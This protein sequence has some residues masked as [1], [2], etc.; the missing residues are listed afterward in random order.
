MARLW[1]HAPLHRAILFS[2]QNNYSAPFIFLSPSCGE[3]EEGV[4]E[5]AAVAVFIDF[6]LQQL[7]LPDLIW[8]VI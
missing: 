1:L 8:M 5:F 3:G 4:L 6:S 2:V 7:Q